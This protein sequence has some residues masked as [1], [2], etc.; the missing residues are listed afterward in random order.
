[1]VF[2]QDLVAGRGGDVHFVVVVEVREGQACI[3]EVVADAVLVA[4]GGS[5]GVKHPALGVVDRLNHRRAG[6]SLAV[7]DASAVV[8][9]V[10]DSSAGFHEFLEF[11]AGGIIDPLDGFQ[12]TGAIKGCEGGFVEVIVGQGEVFV[13]VKGHI[14]IGI[15]PPVGGE[16]TRLEA[17][18]FAGGGGGVE[19][20][21]QAVGTGEVGV[22]KVV[23]L[24]RDVAAATEVGTLALEGC[25]LRVGAM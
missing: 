11:V 7:L 1:M 13:G 8:L 2:L 25:V 20:P 21:L 17:F 16:R 14:P 19:D 6:G 5:G 10:L 12:R 9:G 24:G 3:T 18:G 15:I 22:G 4:R 23:Y